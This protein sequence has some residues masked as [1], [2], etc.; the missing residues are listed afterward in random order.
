MERQPDGIGFKRWLRGGGA[1]GE[2]RA[3]PTWRR[4]TLGQVWGCVKPPP[5]PE[6]SVHALTLLGLADKD[7][8]DQAVFLGLC[9]T[10]VIIAI[11]VVGDLV[12]GLA[13][14]LGDN[15]VELI[16]HL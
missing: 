9:R 1:E 3:P 14:V 16:P 12:F 2:G 5:P 7:I 15:L 11:G 8:I 6:P 4:G 10:H 13:G